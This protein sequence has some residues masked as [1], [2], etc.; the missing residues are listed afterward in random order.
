MNLKEGTILVNGE[1]SIK[2]LG[3]SGSIYHLS[4]PNNYDAYY[5]SATEI[6]LINEGWIEGNQAI[7]LIKENIATK[8]GLSTENIEI[9]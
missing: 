5:S 9:V 7:V 6:Q 3:I 8:F 4:E 1:D 2:V